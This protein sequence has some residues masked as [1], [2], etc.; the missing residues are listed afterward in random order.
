MFEHLKQELKTTREEW[1]EAYEDYQATEK[2]R[3]DEFTKRTQLI[4]EIRKQIEEAGAKVRT[5]VGDLD[6]RKMSEF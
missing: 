3:K 5:K 2:R 4:N 6:M 1:A